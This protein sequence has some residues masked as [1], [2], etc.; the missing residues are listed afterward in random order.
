MESGKI[1]KKCFQNR[2][3]GGTNFIDVEPLLE[4]TSFINQKLIL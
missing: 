4:E 2:L 3:Y 1:H